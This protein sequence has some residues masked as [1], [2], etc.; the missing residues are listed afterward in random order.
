MLKIL[1]VKLAWAKPSLIRA[2]WDLGVLRWLKNLGLYIYIYTLILYKTP[3]Y[4][5]YRYNKTHTLQSTLIEQSLYNLNSP[6]GWIATRSLNKQGFSIQNYQATSHHQWTIGRYAGKNLS[7]TDFLL[8][9][10]LYQLA[11]CWYPNL[12]P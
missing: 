8:C 11:N 4:M 3:F 10:K 12:V 1:P 6:S 2:Y 5:Q 7:W 9:D